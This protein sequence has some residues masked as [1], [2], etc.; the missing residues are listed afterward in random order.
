MGKRR[1][2]RER[3]LQ[4]LYRL[5]LLPTEPR[6][7]PEELNTLTTE[8]GN[9]I[10]QPFAED[11]ISGVIANLPQIDGLIQGAAERWEIGRMAM[12]DK[13]ILRIGVYEI[14]CHKETD[15]AVIINEALEI[16]KRYSTA[17]SASFING[18]LDKIARQERRG[19]D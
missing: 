13:T 10:D 12:I 1:K 14:L 18:I 8:N 6:L 3:A 2:A 15:T 9:T 16:A 4:Y 11:L 19:G 7:I 5:D 17:D